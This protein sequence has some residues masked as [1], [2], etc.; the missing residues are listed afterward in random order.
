[1]VIVGWGYGSL[2]RGPSTSG[3]HLGT[4]AVVAIVVMSQSPMSYNETVAVIT[5]AMGPVVTVLVWSPGR[6]TETAPCNASPR[7]TPL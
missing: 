2:G 6:Q 7:H 1:M 5:V 3:G 4:A